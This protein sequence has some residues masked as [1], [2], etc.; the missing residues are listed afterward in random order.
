MS[1]SHGA[2]EGVRACLPDRFG[3]LVQSP[4]VAEATNHWSSVRTRP[5]Q[6]HVIP[7]GR[8]IGI[9]LAVGRSILDKLIDGAPADIDLARLRAVSAEHSSDW[10]NGGSYRRGKI[11]Q[12]PASV[13]RN[14]SSAWKRS[15]SPWH[16][17][18]NG[19]DIL[20]LRTLTI[21]S[22]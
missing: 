2:L 22:N 12:L 4:S 15:V 10:L 8:R 16:F 9:A 17:A 18:D 13:N 11:N 20:S 14:G 7:R 1:S 6:F 19:R 3:Q 21:L 5:L